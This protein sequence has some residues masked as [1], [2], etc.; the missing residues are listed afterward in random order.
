MGSQTPQTGSVGTI[1]VIVSALI[2][3]PRGEILL[4]RQPKWGDTWTLPGGH[5]KPGERLCDGAR[6]EGEEETGLILTARGLVDWGELID[7]D[8]RSRAFHFIYFDYAFSAESSDVQL[9][10]S[11]IAEGV[12]V[13]PSEVLSYQLTPGYRRTLERYLVSSDGPRDWACR[14]DLTG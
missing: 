5:L 4:I 13:A 9:D 6:R 7:V 10:P 12:W 8:Y 11:E 2:L 1:E 3:N 14:P